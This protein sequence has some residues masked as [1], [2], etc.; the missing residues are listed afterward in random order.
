MH[1]FL[2]A[3]MIVAG[4][5]LPVARATGAEMNLRERMVAMSYLLDAIWVDASTPD[6]Y[7]QA[8]KKVAELREHLVH[9][10]ALLPNRIHAMEPR[11]RAAAVVEYHQLMARTI[12][13]TASL[14]QALVKADFDPVS[15]SRVHDVHNYLREISI[16]VGKGHGR[17]RD[18]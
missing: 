10:I 11:Y 13:L 15:G 14:E 3:L 5:F 6:T 17:F 4:G 1:K 12:H 16:V 7:P 2:V 18:K 9:S 8:A